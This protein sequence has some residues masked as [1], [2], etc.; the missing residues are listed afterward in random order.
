MNDADRKNWMALEFLSKFF[1]NSDHTSPKIN[2][3]PLFNFSIGYF[4]ERSGDNGILKEFSK[5]YECA[6]VEKVLD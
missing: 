4:S 6:M 2:L 1:W 5:N 3:Y